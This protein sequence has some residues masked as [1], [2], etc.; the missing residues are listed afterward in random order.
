[1]LGIPT[2]EID[3]NVMSELQLIPCYVQGRLNSWI[4]LKIQ[5]FES[6]E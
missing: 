2:N 6:F 1:M 5:H 4:L 3:T